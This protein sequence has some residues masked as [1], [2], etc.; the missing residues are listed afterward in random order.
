MGGG[1]V[2]GGTDACAL[3][4]W[5]PDGDKDGSGR[6][7]AGFESCERPAPE[8]WAEVGGDCNDDNGSVYPG[9]SGYF[10]AAYVTGGSTLSFD[11]NCHNGEEPD[12]S[13]FGAAPTCPGSALGCE[14]QGYVPTGRTGAGVN[15]L[16]GSTTLRKCQVDSVVGCKSVETTIAAKR[17]R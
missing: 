14:G 11:Y 17:C 3:R 2:D 7:N 6:S 10:G 15:P 1:V 9:Q 5:F 8:G 13:Q 4:T 12:T 16:C